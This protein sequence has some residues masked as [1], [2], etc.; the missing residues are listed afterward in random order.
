[1][2]P[3]T[4]E[5]H[6]TRALRVACRGE[7]HVE[8]NP[9]VGCVIA[10]GERVLATGWHAK[11]GQEHAEI[12]AIGSAT[13]SLD[14]ATLLVTLE[15]CSHHGKTPPCV[16]AIIDAGIAH[17]IVAQED[18]FPQVAGQG[19]A[20]LR[21]AGIQV[22]VGTLQEQARQLNAPYLTRIQKKRP[23]II[24]K[25]AMTLDGKLATRSGNSQWITGPGARQIVHA[26]RG[27]VDGVMVGRATVMADDPQLTARP[28][29]GQPD[30][31]RVATRIVLDTRAEISLT[32][33]LVQSA[34]RVP[35]IVATGKT[36][37]ESRCERLRQKKCQVVVCG[38]DSPQER[39][40]SLWNHLVEQ[41]MTNVLVEGGGE[42]FGTLFDNGWI[43]ELHAF[44]APKLIGGR[45]A[46]PVIAGDG[47]DRM[48][49]AIALCDPRIEPVGPDVHIHGR[50]VF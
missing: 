32:S 8:P 14:G 28:A 10:R 3:I 15:P 22:T 46:T 16:D 34:E 50:L 44:V 5:H 6:M 49:D 37:L 36:A 11:F 12:A 45:S 48:A 2:Q 38:G 9:M 19:I 35:V 18:P 26:L 27:R 17:V 20:R 47:R 25:W 21:A 1:M 41:G 33:R 23:W 13:E 7:G 40:A 30:P 4:I 39:L 31:P 24:A 42:L 29:E 43:D